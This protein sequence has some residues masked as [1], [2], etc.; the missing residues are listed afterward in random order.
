M[1]ALRVIRILTSSSSSSSSLS[2]LF[3]S[4]TNRT[5]LLPSALSRSFAAQPQT[6]PSAAAAASSTDED[7][8]ANATLPN[9][10][11][12]EFSL[13][14]TPP[15]PS[16][17][18]SY[19]KKPTWDETYRA[20]ANQALFGGKKADPKQAEEEGDEERER[21]ARLAR[22]LLEAALEPPDDVEE[23]HMV[24]KEEDQRS[25][26]VGIIGA[27]NAGKSSLTNFMVGT[28]V[29][30]VS[31]KTNT[32]THEVLGVMTKGNRQICFFDTPGLMIGHHGYPYRADVRVRVESAWR[33]I[34]LYD[35]LIVIFDVHRHLSAPDTRV[36][37]L[38]K[39]LGAQVHPKQKRVLCMNKVDL[40]EDKKDLLKVAK[41]FE[42]LPA[43]DRYFM[44]SGLKGSG[45]KDLVQYLMDQAVKRP[46]DEDPT[47]MS[48]E[49]M[50]NIALEVVREKMLDHIHQEIPYV[51]EHRLMDW[52]ELRDGS[53]RIEQHFIT[54]KHSQRQILVGKNG[55]KIGRIGIEANEELR[56]IFRRQVHLILQ[57]GSG[58][59][60]RNLSKLCQ[61][62]GSYLHGVNL[63]PCCKPHVLPQLLCN[64][65]TAGVKNH[66][67]SI[68][69]VLFNITLSNLQL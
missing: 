68:Q 42:D 49:I 8:D 47:I 45:V 22:V 52:K 21:A 55:S 11:S 27:P 41:E 18:N 54:P 29:A 57:F 60:L 16:S 65:S 37:K 59:A 46:W 44:I 9:F 6:H 7:T 53:L 63:V 33:S 13:H 12:S 40:V 66:D 48:E 20:R 50:K 28:K 62:H 25:L 36:I 19:Q 10:D 64:Q 39:N 43:Y 32:T 14:F 2:T 31:R 17:A 24:V 38:I 35:L 56:S 67:H 58:S 15:D 61:Y 23:E 51:I 69:R 3:S 5:R 4:T 1:K 30:A 26:S 34:D